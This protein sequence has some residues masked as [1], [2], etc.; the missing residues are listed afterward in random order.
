MGATVSEPE[1]TDFHDDFVD[2]DGIETHYWVD[3]PADGTPIVMIHGGGSGADAWGN[4]KYAMPLLAG[5]GFRV[6]AL[7]MVGF[8]QS[9]T[10]DPTEFEYTNQARIDQAIGFIRAMSIEGEANLVGN[11]MGGA[12][13]LGVAMQS[14]ELI[15]RLI[16]VGGAGYR[17]GHDEERSQ[18]SL[19]AL[20]TLTSFDGSRAAMHDVIDVLSVADWYDREAMVDH[21]LA[22][23]ER[24]GVQE[25]HKSTMEIAVTDD[26]SYPDEAFGTVDTET[27]LI[28]GRNDPLMG[29]K[30]PWSIF[31]LIDDS[32]LHILNDCGHWVLVDQLHRSTGIIA[33]FLSHR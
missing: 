20:D 31:N 30:I 26:M 22:N 10:P 23:Y 1:K 32:S 8:G 16:L 24:D 25:A 27:L 12:A 17:R 33:E 19:E 13:S 15:D 14:P 21:R 4:Y 2:A 18:R 6:Y 3:G 29:P 5:K 7:D 11:S 9:A 28:Y